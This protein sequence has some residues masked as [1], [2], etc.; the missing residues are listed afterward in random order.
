MSSEL[1]IWAFSARVAFP[2][3]DFPVC[4]LRIAAKLG[5]EAVGGHAP[6]ELAVEA[7]GGPHL[8]DRRGQRHVGH[9][10]DE[11]T[12]RRAQRERNVDAGVE[13]SPT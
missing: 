5:Q 8:G 1:Q 13:F 6:D 12:G 2:Q 3:S 10:E 11:A 4:G 9:V 7:I